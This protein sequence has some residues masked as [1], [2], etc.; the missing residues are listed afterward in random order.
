MGIT[1]TEWI[2]TID[3]NGSKRRADAN[4]AEMVADLHK[5][6]RTNYDT[7]GS[8]SEC[9]CMSCNWSRHVYKKP[10]KKW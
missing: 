4:R 5:L 1:Q 9:A 8:V 2:K 7:P 6:D 10:L 3:K